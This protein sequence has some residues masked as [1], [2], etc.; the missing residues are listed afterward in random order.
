MNLI[1][2]VDE[3]WNIGYNNDLLEKISEDLKNFKRLTINST[4]IMGRKTFESL[5]GKKAL[6]KRTNIILSSSLSLENNEEIIV[7]HSL[8]E[9]FDKIKDIPTEKIFIIGGETIYKQFLPFCDTAFVTKIHN[10][11]TADKSMVN[12]DLDDNWQITEKGEILKNINNISYQFLIY[13]Q[14][15]TK[16]L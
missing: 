8:N 6:P 3:C 1:V 11:Y 15:S 13:K 10:S 16:L 14:K 2:A 5:P 4:I 7:C 9:V 12:L